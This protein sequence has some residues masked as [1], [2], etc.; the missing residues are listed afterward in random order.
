MKAAP[1][2]LLMSAL[3]VGRAGF[4]GD[5]PNAQTFDSNGVKIRYTVEGQG[6][7]V[8][9]I[10]GLYSSADINWRLYQADR[11]RSLVDPSWCP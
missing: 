6:E 7:P 5:A 3:A 4:A 2:L 9:L 8:V 1:A 11:F 10:H